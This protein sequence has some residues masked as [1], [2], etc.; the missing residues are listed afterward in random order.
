MPVP[1]HGA[2]KRSDEW[3][4]WEFL[5]GGDPPMQGVAILGNN[6]STAFVRGARGR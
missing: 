2:K 6:H 3:F 4:S 1:K 5:F